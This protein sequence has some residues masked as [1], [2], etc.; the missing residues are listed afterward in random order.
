MFL[1]R[2]VQVFKYHY[3]PTVSFSTSVSFTCYSD[4]HGKNIV[5]RTKPQTST[6][7]LYSL[8]D[9][10]ELEAKLRNLEHIPAYR[11]S[12]FSSA[13]PQKDFIESNI[14]S[15]DLTRLGCTHCTGRLIL[16]L[17]QPH[18]SETEAQRRPEVM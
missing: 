4:L 13:D 14:V 18:K 2:I 10:Q 5:S 7:R 17:I 9:I 8:C 15:Y 12:I 1:G 16:N 6:S 3:V 11:A